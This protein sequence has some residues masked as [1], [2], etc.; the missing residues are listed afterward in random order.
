MLIDT[1]S[2]IA[3]AHVRTDTFACFLSCSASKFGWPLLYGLKLSG[4][5]VS[6]KHFMFFYTTLLYST[7]VVNIPRIISSASL[8]SFQWQEILGRLLQLGSLLYI[9]LKPHPVAV[10]VGCF[11]L[12][13]PLRDS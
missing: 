8:A 1:N 2:C 9:T 6:C 5:G 4:L 3:F 13:L 12:L 7:S 10:A 11:A